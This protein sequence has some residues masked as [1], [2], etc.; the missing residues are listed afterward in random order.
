[1]LSMMKIF[2]FFFF[3][4]FMMIYNKKIMFYYNIYF[5]MSLIFLFKF[6]FKDF[7][8]LSVS[9]LWKFDFYSFY[10][11]LLSMWI[12]GLM[13]M[14][15]QLNKEVLVKLMVFMMMGLILI[16][17]F[18]LSNLMMFYLVFELSLIPTFIMIVYWGYNFERLSASFY[19]LMYTMFISLPLLMYIMKLYK[20]NQTL[21]VDLLKMSNNYIN[22]SLLDYLILFMAFLIKM[23]IF[24]F[25]L[26]L[27][28]AHVE[29]PV[30]GSMVLAAILLKLGS[31]GL[32]RFMEIFYFLSMKY[33]C[34]FMS[35]GIVG[36]V[37]ISLVCL[38][39]IDMKSLVAYSSIVHM[40]MML[41]CMY[42]MVKLSF[43]SS[44]ILMISHGLCSSGL[45]YMVNL[46]YERSQSRLMFFNKGMLSIYPSL[47][48]WWMGF[49]AM[50][51]SFPLSLNFISEIFLI[52]VIVSWDL[53]LMTY[54]M[55]ICFFN[56]AYSLYLYSYVQHGM[57]YVESK[58]LILV[59]FSD[60][61]ILI[62]H[63]V[64]LI[65]LLFNLV[66]VY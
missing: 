4:Y 58:N 44:Y 59:Y 61:M 10:L 38:V 36:G 5:L 1:M 33:S 39:Q 13:L 65:M 27:P 56:S 47:S 31:Y 32:L 28:K 52:S 62:L 29:A 51:F 21:E 19:L 8:W 16:M 66:M 9:F 7:I 54:L 43:I 24:L 42:T 41:C 6:M 11:I 22:L 63:F 37:Y 64:P 12:L 18:S 34:V 15:I 60:Y 35:V 49:C 20:V 2:F 30:Y 55:V 17:S 53:M 48:L 40:N 46:Y 45:F 50:N 3:S 26:W 23:P 57:L 14:V 25:H